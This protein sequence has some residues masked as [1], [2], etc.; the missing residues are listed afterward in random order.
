MVL[1]QLPQ[2]WIQAL[3]LSMHLL[4][5][6]RFREVLSKGGFA[7]KSGW[8]CNSGGNMVCTWGFTCIFSAHLKTAGWNNMFIIQNTKR[9]LSC[10]WL[11][12]T[13]YFV[14]E[15]VYCLFKRCKWMIWYLQMQATCR[16][17][18]QWKCGEAGTAGQSGRLFCGEA[19][20]VAAKAPWVQ[21]LETEA[22]PH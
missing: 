8:G 3:T 9:D 2:K 1:F 19:G 13:A 17:R 18:Q 10:F 20:R 22:S 16:G 15:T 4:D 14:L 5:K 7:L 11:Y 21:G 6:F 12:V